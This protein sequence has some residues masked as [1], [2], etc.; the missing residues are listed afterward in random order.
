MPEIFT[1]YHLLKGKNHQFASSVLSHIQN[2]RSIFWDTKEYSRDEIASSPLRVILS[3]PPLRWAWYFLL[4]GFL[5]YL[6]FNAKRK[7]RIVP[8]I[9]PLQN[10]TVDF[11]KTIANLYFQE[12][13]YRTILDKRIVYFL[14]RVRS[15]FYLDTQV[16]DDKFIH[17]LQLKS[18]RSKELIEK[19]IKKISIKKLHRYLSENDLVELNGFLEDFWKTKS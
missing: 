6:V 14:E 12:N 9:V 18:G 2:K 13:H 4:I 19:I 5:L 11:T 8:I 17:K 7:Q 3:H 16:L 10:T 15:D 1:N